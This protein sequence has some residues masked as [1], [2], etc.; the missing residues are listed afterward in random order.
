MLNPATDADLAEAAALIN[1]SYRGEAAER[2]WTHENSY[3]SGERIAPVE[4]A[5]MRAARPDGRL[6]LHRGDEGAPI[7][8][9]WLEPHGDGAW[10][11]GLLAVEPD[12]QDRKLGRALLEEAE[13]LARSQGGRRMRLTVVHLRE[14]LIAW[15][16]RRGYVLTGETE[17]F[18]QPALASRDLHLVVLE[19]PL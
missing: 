14:T 5:D 1:V 9:L 2:G 6:L 11:L 16:Q 7:G 19:K 17:P 8:C 13:T 18:P 10:H 4:L 3:I 12:R 15:Y